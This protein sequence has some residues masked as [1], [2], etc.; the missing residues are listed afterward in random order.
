VYRASTLS[1]RGKRGI[2]SPWELCLVVCTGRYAADRKS[3]QIS[4]MVAKMEKTG[5]GQLFPREVGLSLHSKEYP[6]KHWSLKVQELCRA[7]P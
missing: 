1:P 6:F 4:S 3:L 7:M 2:A 5:H